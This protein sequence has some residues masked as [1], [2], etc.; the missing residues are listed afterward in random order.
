MPN[1]EPILQ[2]VLGITSLGLLEDA[3]GRQAGND[4]GH[5]V[6]CLL[7]LLLDSRV[8]DLLQALEAELEQAEATWFP[9]D[10]Q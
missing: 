8:C 3:K 5:Q 9:T 7:D 2:K 6:E 1:P 4:D 10:S